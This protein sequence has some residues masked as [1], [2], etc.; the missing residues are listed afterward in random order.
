MLTKPLKLSRF[1]RAPTL[2]TLIH[3]SLHAAAI[4]VPSLCQ[5]FVQSASKVTPLISVTAK[6]RVR[7]CVSLVLLQR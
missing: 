2:A 6:V 3:L 1:L 5:A 7:V 4:T